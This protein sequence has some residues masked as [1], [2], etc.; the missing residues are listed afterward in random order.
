LGATA[1]QA[2][3]E[4]PL[5]DVTLRGRILRPDGKP[6]ANT[7]LR[8]DAVE[9]DGGFRIF[10]FF[11]TF[12]LSTLSCFSPDSDLCPVGSDDTTRFNSTTDANG[13]YSFTFPNAHYRG[14]QT[15]TDYYLSV[16]MPSAAGGGRVAVAS[17][18]LELWDAVH[19]APDVVMWDPSVTIK[20]GAHEYAVAYKPRSQSTNRMRVTIGANDVAGAL[21]GDGAIDARAIEDQTVNVMLNASKDERAARTIYHQRFIS[22]QFALRGGLVPLSR[23]AACSATRSDGSGAGVCNHTDGD[24]I[25]PGFVPPSDNSPV[26]CRF[27]RT[28]ET[29]TTTVACPKPYDTV[30]IDLGAAKQVGEVRTRCGCAMTGSVDGKTWRTLPASGVLGSPQSLRYVRVTGPSAPSSPEISVW[31]PWPDGVAVTPL[32]P[33]GPAG[34]IAAPV[35]PGGARGN[36]GRPWLLAA[37]ALAVLVVTGRRVYAHARHA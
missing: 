8:V 17:Y 3:E 34:S 23:G 4:P 20:P 30:T 36:D 24:L 18:E 13:R 26:E 14:E 22:A 32:V 29:T 37:V 5:E 27:P 2:Q 33:D 19:D 12:G 9:D 10:S 25:A 35:D 1:A 21:R 28:Y 16:A 7:A 6:L 11:A 31:P 15:N